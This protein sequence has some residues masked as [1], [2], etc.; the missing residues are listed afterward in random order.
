[1]TEEDITK[2]KFHYYVIVP[3]IRDQL[4]LD[5][6]QAVL[7][8]AIYKL[9]YNHR[10]ETG[11]CYASKEYLAK[12]VGVKRSTMFAHLKTLEDKGLLVRHPQTSY[13]KCGGQYLEMLEYVERGKDA[14]GKEGQSKIWTG[15]PGPPDRSKSGRGTVQNLDSDSSESGRNKY[16]DKDKYYKKE[17]ERKTESNEPDGSTL[18]VNQ[19]DNSLKEEEDKGFQLVET[20]KGKKS[21]ADYKRE[22]KECYPD[23]GGDVPEGHKLRKSW[24]VFLQVWSI[25]PKQRRES[26]QEAWGAWHN[27]TRLESEE[28]VRENK[29]FLKSIGQH[30]VDMKKSRDWKRGYAPQMRTYLNQKS[31]EGG[32]PEEAEEPEKK[33][34]VAEPTRVKGESGFRDMM[35]RNFIG[36]LENHSTIEALKRKY[37]NNLDIIEEIEKELK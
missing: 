23:R 22:A 26:R 20:K 5:N 24:E 3:E 15:S 35:K 37:P 14:S 6:N 2:L 21:E 8:D 12:L 31:W 7:L 17:K 27:A 10:N 19:F 32:A 16:R 9:S 4:G 28:E 13:L 33:S 11:W 36:Q 1:M 29:D 25:Y 18:N 30:I 34:R